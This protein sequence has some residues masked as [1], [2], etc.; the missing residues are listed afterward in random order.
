M[1]DPLAV[2]LLSRA[3][4]IR[5]QNPNLELNQICSFAFGYCT[6]IPAGSPRYIPACEREQ[7]NTH[8]RDSFRTMDIDELTEL[9]ARQRTFDGAR[10]FSFPP[11]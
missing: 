10:V 3:A 5:N 1:Y 6:I 4:C 11:S 2:A 9:R 8:R 7:W